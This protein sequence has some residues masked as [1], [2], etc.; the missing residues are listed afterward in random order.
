MR[1]DSQRWNSIFGGALTPLLTYWLLVTLSLLFVVQTVFAVS[2]R[3]LCLSLTSIRQIYPLFLAPLSHANIGH[4]FFNLLTLFLAGRHLETFLGTGGFAVLNGVA[5]VLTTAT[6]LMLSIFEALFSSNKFSPGGCVVGFSSVIFA[7][8]AF[9][10]YVADQAREYNI[11]LFFSVR[12]RYVP[13]ALLGL[14]FF[15][16]PESSFLGHLAGV[17]I[18]LALALRTG[19]SQWA[20]ASKYLHGSYVASSRSFAHGDVIGLSMWPAAAGISSDGDGGNSVFVMPGA[21][22]HPAPFRHVEDGNLTS[23]A[24]SGGGGFIPF[25]GAGKKLGA[26]SGGSS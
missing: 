16:V 17:F 9:E 25:Q 12:A 20:E 23:S 26:S 1:F 11:C 7:L 3:S 22:Q 14:T 4:L 13:W 21:V 2:T 24:T 8:I 10:S 19:P 15:L 18:G 6:F 5:L